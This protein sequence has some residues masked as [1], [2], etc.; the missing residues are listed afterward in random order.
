[1]MKLYSSLTAVFAGGLVAAAVALTTFSSNPAEA[2]DNE[3]E[4]TYSVDTTRADKTLKVVFKAQKGYYVNSAFPMTVELKSESV[5][6]AKKKLGK[7]DGEWKASGKDGKALEVTFAVP[8][9]GKGAIDGAYRVVICT[10]KSCSAPLKGTF[11][12]K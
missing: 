7:K 12:A 3:W 11:A 6:L 9:T 2:G 1:M 8:A 5:D 10:D 4:G